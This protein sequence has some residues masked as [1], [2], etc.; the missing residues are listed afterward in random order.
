MFCTNCGHDLADGVKFCIYCGTPVK[1]MV[2]PQQLQP[3]PEPVQAPIPEPVQEY[4][5]EP[6][7]EPEPA[8][9]PF[10]APE[11]VVQP[12]PVWE[13]PKQ[14]PA[15][16]APEPQ[17]M[18]QWQPQQDQ[19]QQPQQDQWQQ[20]Q[21]NQW[22]PQQDQWQP[23]QNQWQPQPQNQWQQ[24]Q[25][26]WTG[27]EPEPEPKKSK[28]WIWI[29]AGAVVLAGIVVAII[30]ILG[31]GKSGKDDSSEVSTAIEESSEESKKEESSEESKQES[32]EESSEKSSAESSAESQ[33]ESSEEA[34]AESSAESQAESSAESQA[35]SSAESQA[36]SST[37]PQAE[38]STETSEPEPV[39]EGEVKT[40]TAANGV[41]ITLPAELTTQDIGNGIM[42]TGSEMIIYAAFYDN[43]PNNAAIYGI[44]DFRETIKKYPDML[45]QMM[46][47]T[48]MTIGETQQE[49][50]FGD[51]HGDISDFTVSYEDF[52]GKGKVYLMEDSSNYGIFLLYYVAIDQGKNPAQA[53]EKAEAA[54]QTV[55]APSTIGPKRLYYIPNDRSFM[56]TAKEEYTDTYI[57]IS[58]SRIG[59]VL[60]NAAGEER[61]VTVEMEDL[62]SYGLSGVDDYLNAYTTAMGAAGT[63]AASYTVG[64]YP[65]RYTTS[66][67]TDDSGNTWSYIMASYTPG[68]GIYYTIYAEGSQEEI[69]NLFPPVIEDIVW[70][71]HIGTLA[72][73]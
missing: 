25:Q 38:S 3:A 14:E 10:V 28:L 62:N 69:E 46:G 51:R 27:M 53:A 13:A 7:A 44:E 33:A 56:F 61:Y 49:V 63:P 41:G 39:A 71:F 67:Y 68:G 18:N 37:E 70:S 20:P 36:E 65:F 59:L 47:V 55:T 30:L 48:S 54:M 32:K 42:A 12:E 29:V 50:T 1:P 45:A 4:V 60:Y 17:P 40:L 66:V 16:Q 43:D 35:E 2:D 11:P 64:A 19:W 31:K 52:S 6:V 57:T 24:P 72:G 8:P 21:Q 9:E 73:Y 15:W 34:S 58:D 22:Q 5:P 26:N 23:Q